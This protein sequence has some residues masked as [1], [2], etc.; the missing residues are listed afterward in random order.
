MHVPRV[1]VVDDHLD[2]LQL[3]ENALSLEGFLVTLASNGD[4]ALQLASGGFDA[5]LTNLA[6]PGMDGHELI[7]TLRDL[8]RSHPVPI[9]LISGQVL[10]NPAGI[11][12]GGCCALMKKPCDLAALAS[13]LRQL[14]DT[15]LHDCSRCQHLKGTRPPTPL[16]HTAR[17]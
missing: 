2:T 17:C 4:Q 10:T 8:H 14:I 16:P 3:F 6:M 15:C 12:G 1:L 9:V 11:A 5:V 7:R 13:T